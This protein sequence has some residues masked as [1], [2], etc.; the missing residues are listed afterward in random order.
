MPRIIR[1]S[2]LIGAAREYALG[3]HESSADDWDLP[4][5]SEERVTESSPG[6][7]APPSMGRQLEFGAAAPK[8]LTGGRSLMT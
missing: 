7:I 8:P 4:D 2:D 1:V 6:P 5:I 3:S